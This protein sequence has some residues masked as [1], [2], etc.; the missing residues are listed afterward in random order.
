MPGIRPEFI[1]Q[2]E[3]LQGLKQLNY[4]SNPTLRWIVHGFEKNF[5]KKLHELK[6]TWNQ[7]VRAYYRDVLSLNTRETPLQ[8][9]WKLDDNG[10]FIRLVEDRYP[11]LDFAELVTLRRYIAEAKQVEQYFYNE[12]DASNALHA[13]RRYAE[14]KLKIYNLKD[15]VKTLFHF[16]RRSP[17][18]DIFGSNNL[19]SHVI[20]IYIVPCI[21]FSMLIEEDFL[22]MAIGTLAH[23]LAHGFHH[24]GADKDGQTW[25]EFS[26]VE[27][28]LVEGLAEF[29]TR[30]YARS[31]EGSRPEVLRAFKKTANYL[32]DPYRRYEQWGSE[33]GLETVYQAFIEARRNDIRTFDAFENGLKEAGRRLREGK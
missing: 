16:F 8:V 32:P 4:C 5:Q 9:I 15:I 27:L 30:E 28:E 10:C 24:I 13:S 19:K 26:Q 6:T 2:A 3:L 22:D 25:M 33:R 12:P 23:E 29:Y 18:A 14:T 21:V 31:I 7:K 1:C 11:N 20:E 17:N